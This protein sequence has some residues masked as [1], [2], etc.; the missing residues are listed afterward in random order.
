MRL[1][2]DT[3]NTDVG[4]AMLKAIQADT[5]I[6]SDFFDGLDKITEAV[7]ESR[8]ELKNAEFTINEARKSPTG[9]EG[10]MEVEI[11]KEN[12]EK[13]LVEID[14]PE[15]L[16]QRSKKFIDDSVAKI[17]EHETAPPKKGTSGSDKINKY[18][19]IYGVY[20]GIKVNKTENLL[21][22]DYYR[23]WKILDQ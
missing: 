14:V 4:E 9:V 12:G 2:F 13:V 8:P 1:G 16:G 20:L 5:L 3:P 7:S 10:K 21:K 18:M 19:G 22:S 6:K 15:G 17:N 11:V 23:L